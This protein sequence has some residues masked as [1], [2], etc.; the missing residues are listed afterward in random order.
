[1]FI[2]LQAFAV[3][4]APLYGIASKRSL[5]DVDVARQ[6]LQAMRDCAVAALN[7]APIDKNAQLHAALTPFV[8]LAN[9]TVE[10]LVG[11]LIKPIIIIFRFC[12][13]IKFFCRILL[14]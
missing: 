10:R 5:N 14:L 4:L 11:A 12:F 8:Q 7:A 2:L 3:E 6:S 13:T 1:M 9:A